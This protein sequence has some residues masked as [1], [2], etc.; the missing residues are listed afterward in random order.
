MPLLNV[1]AEKAIQWIWVHLETCSC[2]T[3]SSQL[4]GNRL[5]PIQD[6]SYLQGTLDHS[7]PQKHSHK[8]LQI[9]VCQCILPQVHASLI[10][11][12]TL[13][14][15]QIYVLLLCFSIGIENTVWK[16]IWKPCRQVSWSFLGRLAHWWWSC[17]HGELLCFA[18]SLLVEDEMSWAQLSLDSLLEMLVFEARC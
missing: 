17:F 15:Q 18:H 2:K 6:L 1:L 7:W 14:A 12:T 8:A 9:F 4:K 13:H 3:I 11:E 5:D 16:N 10:P